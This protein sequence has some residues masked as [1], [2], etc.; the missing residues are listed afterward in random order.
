MSSRPTKNQGPPPTVPTRDKSLVQRFM[1][2]A[3]TLQFAWFTGHAVVLISSILYLFK[4]S[5]CYYRLVYLGVIES[6]G[7]IIYQQ[8]FTRNEPLQTQDAA[9]TKAS[10]KSRIAGLLKSEDVLYLVLAIFW[11]ATPRFSLSLIP[12]F[13]FAVFHVLIYV[14]KVIFPKVFLLSSKDSSKILSFIDRFVVQ[15][16][17]LCMHW[18]GTAELLI[19]ILVLF[20]AILCFQRSWIMLVVYAVFI[21]L[22]YENSKYMKAAFA[23][24]RVRMDGIISHPSVPPYVKRAYNAVKMSL[25]HLS[26]FRLSG[27]PQATKKQ[28]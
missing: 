2:V 28:N 12:F 11:L 27:T 20:R 25:V 1:A 22:R 4:M 15:Y 8:F 5:E 19:F 9:A 7:I 13:A 23:Q 18:V 10:V 3:K 6:F 16:N 26:E 17:D 24:W 14:E 21:K